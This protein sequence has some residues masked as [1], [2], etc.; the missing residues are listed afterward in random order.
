MNRTGHFAL[1]VGWKHKS[2]YEVG[3]PCPGIIGLTAVRYKESPAVNH[4]ATMR[5]ALTNERNRVNSE[6]DARINGCE[7]CRKENAAVGTTEAV[8]RP[9]SSLRKCVTVLVSRTALGY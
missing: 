3:H 8:R 7:R 5:Q 2:Q 9:Q 6:V 4:T 1:P